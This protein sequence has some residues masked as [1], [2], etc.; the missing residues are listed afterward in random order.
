MTQPAP[1]IRFADD[2]LAL[3]ARASHDVNPLHLDDGYARATPFGRRVVFGVLGALACLAHAPEVPGQRLRALTLEFVGPMFADT[4]YNVQA[5]RLADDRIGVTLGDGARPLVKATL[6]LAPGATRP[7]PVPDTPFALRREAADG[8]PDTLAAGSARAGR[9]APDPAAVD[10]LRARLGLDGRLVSPAQVAALLWS[11]YLVGMEL[12]GRQALFNGLTLDFADPAPPGAPLDFAATVRGFDPRFGLLRTNVLLEADGAPFAKGEIRAFVRRAAAPEDDDLARW[13]G[14]SDSLAGKTAL[15]IG[16]SRG[17]GAR[18]ARALALQGATVYGN[19]LRSGASFEQTRRGAG[20][21]AER[22]IAAPGD[23]A[24]PL[25]CAQ[26]VARIVAERGGLDL[27]VCN[28]CPAILPMWYEAATADRIHRYVADSLALASTPLAA[29]LD[30]LA[31]RGGQAVVISSVY[32]EKAPANFPHYVA[33]KCAIEGLVRAVAAH[34][35]RVGFVLVRPP[36]LEGELNIPFGGET[37]LSVDQVAGTIAW[38][39][40]QPQTPGAVTWLSD[41]APRGEQP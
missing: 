2:D 17:L 37:S 32:A 16:A 40:T 25:W 20:D 7:D 22:L 34:H 21:A 4:D 15:V 19:Y 39:T 41:F 5:R 26:T 35:T 8:A 18:I 29:S 33:A 27:L 11:S 30:A 10:A 9:Y 24:D 6:R 12:P 13:I 3:F 28:A 31:E 14:P 23:G 38:Q 1:T 36:R